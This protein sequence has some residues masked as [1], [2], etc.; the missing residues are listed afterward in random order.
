MHRAYQFTT[1]DLHAVWQLWR[2]D[3][4]PSCSSCSLF[5]RSCRSTS[6]KFVW[7]VSAGQTAW[8]TCQTWTQVV[9]DY[10]EVGRVTMTDKIFGKLGRSSNQLYQ[11]AHGV[12][13]FMAR[14]RPATD[15]FTKVRH[16]ITGTG[17]AFNQYRRQGTYH[18]LRRQ[19]YYCRLQEET[20]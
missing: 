18:L 7:F 19:P 13:V 2:R 12:R 14:R 4:R 1:P 16:E 20:L 8:C 3:D 15:L 17:S 5:S 9:C 10:W 11:I 6:S